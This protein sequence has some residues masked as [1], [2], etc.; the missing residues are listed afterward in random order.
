MRNNRPM[1]LRRVGVLAVTVAIALAACGG[2]DP[3][4]DAPSVAPQSAGEPTPEAS[5]STGYAPDT[6][7]SVIEG[8][9]RVRSKPSVDEDSI[10]FTPLLDTGQRLYVMSGPVEGSGYTGW[11]L[12]RPVAK[13][14]TQDGWV[15]A[16]ARDGTPWLEPAAVDCPSV[17]TLADIDAMDAAVRVICFAGRELTFTATVVWGAN[18]GDANILAKPDWMAACLSTFRWGSKT[19]DVFVA[20]PPELADAA[21]KHKLN[22]S[23][24]A[25]VVAHLDDPAALTC[26][27]KTVMNADPVILAATVELDC[28]AMF[29][30]TEFVKQ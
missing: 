11:Y 2:T 23:F 8:P 22:D 17:P 10:K 3:A 12:V 30:A 5:I 21:G 1:P 20:V 7:L 29:V 15:S 16:A 28:R 9:L 26:E 18:C 19:S 6:L 25:R 13:R 4:T 27:P 14:V 24:K